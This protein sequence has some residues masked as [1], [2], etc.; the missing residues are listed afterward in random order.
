MSELTSYVGGSTHMAVSQQLV[1]NFVLIRREAKALA[2]EAGRCSEWVWK[3]YA[4]QLVKE[5]D[6]A[7]LDAAHE[8]AQAEAQR[9]AQLRLVTD[10]PGDQ[11]GD[12]DRA[13]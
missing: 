1:T 8:L 12:V 2:Q 11:A 3:G 5:M 13:S 4:N 7:L 10:A 6:R 9:E